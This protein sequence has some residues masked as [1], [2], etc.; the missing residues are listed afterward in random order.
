MTP[1][2]LIHRLVCVAD[3]PLDMG[4][5]LVFMLPFEFFHQK[6]CVQVGLFTSMKAIV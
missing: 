6:R 1:Q 3:G 5:I 4:V 2:L